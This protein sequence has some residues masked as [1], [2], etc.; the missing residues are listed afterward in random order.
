MQLQ[1][2]DLNLLVVLDA[3]LRH[4]SVKQA[5]AAIGLSPSATSHA[6]ARLRELLDDPLLVRAGR[7]MVL[8]PR[9]EGLREE[10]AEVLGR[11]ERMLTPQQAID[12]TTFT[13]SFRVAATDYT[14]LEILVPLCRRLSSLAPGVDIHAQRQPLDIVASLRADRCELVVG[15]FRDPPPNVRVHELFR[16]R[17][18][19][20]MR[21]GHPASR[22]RLSVSRYSK[23]DHILVAPGGQPRGIVDELLA[24]RGHSRR[25]ARCVSSFHVAPHLVAGS[26]YVLTIASQI[27]AR[28]AD[29]LD[30]VIRKPPLDLPRF[31]L[32]MIWHQRYDQDLG[33]RWLREQIAAL[34]T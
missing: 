18:V 3:V 6:L 11:V 5:A 24:A 14:E 4:A 29:E 16:E 25:V 26:D 33:H 28:Y 30:L 15:V 7:S 9:A 32:C 22:G 1:T 34:Q 12:P 19:V 10:L 23:L 13:R 17:F 8:T 20:V 2:I 27:A 31:P 21:R